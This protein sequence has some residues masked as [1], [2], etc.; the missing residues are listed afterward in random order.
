VLLLIRLSDGFRQA[1]LSTVVHI[2]DAHLLIKVVHGLEMA[3]EQLLLVFCL[4]LEDEVAEILVPFDPILQLVQALE[5]LLG[6]Y[7]VFNVQTF[8][9][10][11]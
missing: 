10:R 4:E 7:A 1:Q 6:N 9:L 8:E 3:H 11:D 2:A 5:L